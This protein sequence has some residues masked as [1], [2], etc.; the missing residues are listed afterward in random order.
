MNIMNPPADWSTLKKLIWLRGTPIN[1]GEELTVTGTPPLSLP[2]SLGKPLKAW[3][4]D[5]MPYQEGTGDPAPDNVRPIYGTDKLTITTAG[6]NLCDG[7]AYSAGLNTNRPYIRSMTSV[8][9]PFTTIDTYSG[10][11]FVVPVMAGVT[12]SL[13]SDITGSAKFFYGM[14]RNFADITDLTKCL[15]YANVTSTVT[16]T[17][18]GYMVFMRY[19]AASGSTVTWSYA[20]AEF[21]STVTPYTPYIAPSQTVIDVPPL[22]K[23]LFNPSVTIDAYLDGS[24]VL[25]YNN[26]FK[27]VVVPIK[28]GETYTVKQTTLGAWSSRVALSNSLEHNSLIYSPSSK[29]V[30]MLA[31]TSPYSFTFTNTD[32]Q[33]LIFSLYRISADGDNYDSIT[34]SV[35]V[36]LGSTPSSY[37][38]F[39]NTIYNGTI[40]SEGGESRWGEVDLGTLTWYYMASWGSSPSNFYAI[41]SGIKHID[42][43]AMPNMLVSIYKPVKAIDMYQ[44][45]NTNFIAQNSDGVRISD[46]RFT[47]RDTFKAAM[48]GIK[49][50]YELA[51]PTSITLTAP[52]IPTPT[53]TATTWATAED[54]TVDGMEVTYVGKA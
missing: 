33:Y 44:S 30:G 14:Y 39:N 1:G 38:P 45:S 53:G 26:D 7:I 18:D 37:E 27:S 6:K 52:T 29:N 54:G 28:H 25:Y 23:N 13:S 50:Y 42:A 31:Y 49:L 34:G 2:N 40:G 51:T 19:N 24:Q 12:Y 48:Q 20:Q 21:G 22:G 32:F 8:T 4:V 47:D 16:P 46:A 35:Q 5:V 10:V 9:S 43:T 36:E 15:E 41:V 11:G 17:Y 3:S